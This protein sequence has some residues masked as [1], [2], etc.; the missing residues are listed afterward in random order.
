MSDEHDPGSDAQALE[1]IAEVR[2][3][4]LKAFNAADVDG[5]IDVLTEDVVMDPWTGP[6]ISGRAGARDL[7]ATM[8]SHSE[9]SARYEIDEIVIMGEWAFD[10]GNWYEHIRRKATGEELDAVFGTLQLYR[11]DDQQ[12]KLAR[13]I[14]N[15]K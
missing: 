8:L 14:W 11:R 10:R 7:L 9:F 2:D 5:F 12:W 4:E 3:L 1:R 6:A 15:R 13:L